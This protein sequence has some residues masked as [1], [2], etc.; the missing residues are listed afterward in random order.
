[1]RAVWVHHAA[2]LSLSIILNLLRIPESGALSPLHDKT[3]Q[4]MGMHAK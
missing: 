3:L 4:S 1:M 2:S